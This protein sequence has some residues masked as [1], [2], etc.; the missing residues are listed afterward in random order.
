[1]KPSLLL[2]VALVAANIVLAL[3]AQT[4]LPA[5]AFVPLH[6]GIG[7]DQIVRLPKP[8]ALAIMPAVAVMVIGSLV[9]GA[10]SK[11][12]ERSRIAYGALIVGVAGVFLVSEVAIVQRLASP[13]FDVLRPVFL[14]VAVMLLIV[15]NYLG[16]ARQNAVFG[17]RTP[18]T[19]ANARV[20]D[21][22][23]RVAGRLMVLAGLALIPV[24]LLVPETVPLVVVMV[25][26]TA[27]PP[28]WAALYSRS[29]WRRQRQ[30]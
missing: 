10:R 13:S 6:Q 11:A 22:T 18:W 27:G 23:H 20:W 17:I 12:L 2:G 16:K 24:S 26:L 4:A 9:A 1:M 7:L 30:A 14:S 28:V 8:Y 19:L 5:S 15:G 21:K 29:L 3:W 25:T